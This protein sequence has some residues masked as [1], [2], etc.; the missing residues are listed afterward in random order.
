MKFP[1]LPTF[2]YGWDTLSVAL[3]EPNSSPCFLCP[4]DSPFLFGSKCLYDIETRRAGGW[5]E[6]CDSRRAE[7]HDRCADHG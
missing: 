5:H 1:P 3:G 2:N 7:E 6:C 4:D